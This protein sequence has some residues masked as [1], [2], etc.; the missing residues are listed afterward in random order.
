MWTGSPDHHFRDWG[1]QLLAV[2]K[3]GSG[4]GESMAAAVVSALEH[5]SRGSGSRDVLRHHGIQ[6]RPQKRGLCPHRTENG[7]RPAAFRLSS[8]PILEL[9]VHAVFVRVL[10]CSSSPE[11]LLFKRFQTS[12]ESID[13]KGLRHGNHGGGSGDC[14]ED[15]QDE[16]LRWTLQV[17]QERED[18]CDDYRELVKLVIIFLGGAPPGLG[19]LIPAPGANAQA[20][21]MSKVL[22]S[23][24]IWM[25]R[26]SSA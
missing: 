19:N 15:V 25:F 21:W 24:K 22:Y 13:R 1:A 14:S 2:A 9:V 5:G 12:W 6:H 17:L 23:F 11:H 8:T 18:L 4:T 10:G 16:A 20:R 7:E 26:A 3:L